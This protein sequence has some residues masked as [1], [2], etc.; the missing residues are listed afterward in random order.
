MAASCVGVAARLRR[1]A[2]KMSWSRGHIAVPVGSVCR[3]PRVVLFYGCA[4]RGA[5]GVG[6]SLLGRA[7]GTPPDVFLT[8]VFLRRRPPLAL[9]LLSVARPTPA[10]DGEEAIGGVVFPPFYPY[11]YFFVFRFPAPV[12]ADP[13]PFFHSPHRPPTIRCSVFPFPFTP[14]SRPT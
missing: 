3:P 7:R 11:S 1:Y 2:A 5:V 12:A 8:C 14:S 10:A 6:F 9:S 4:R 13:A